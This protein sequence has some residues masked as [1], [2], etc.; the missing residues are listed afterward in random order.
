LGWLVGLVR[1]LIRFNV[2]DNT[3]YIGKAILDSLPYL[4]LA[5]RFLPFLANEMWKCMPKTLS[6]IMGF[7]MKVAVLPK[8]CATLCTQAFMGL[9]LVGFLSHGVEA[10]SHFILTCGRYLVVV[11]FNHRPSSTMVRYMVKRM[12]FEESTGATGK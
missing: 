4:S 5:N 12:Y 10:S 11:Y 9:N 8:A 6:P 7:G 3:N 2:F 1:A